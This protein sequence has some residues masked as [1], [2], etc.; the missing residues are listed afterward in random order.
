VIE[1]LLKIALIKLLLDKI[2]QQARILVLNNKLT[3]MIFLTILEHLK[4]I[5]LLDAKA[6]SILYRNTLLAMDA[7][8]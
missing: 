8:L 4:Q 2:P 3:I 6:I 1:I 7:Y 5:V